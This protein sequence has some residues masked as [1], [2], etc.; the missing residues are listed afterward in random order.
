MTVVLGYVGA[1]AARAMYDRMAVARAM[2]LVYM[3][4]GGDRLILVLE[5]NRFWVRRNELALQKTNLWRIDAGFVVAGLMKLLI[6][7]K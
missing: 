7:E 2:L 1:L 3:A 4:Y 6:M 5:E